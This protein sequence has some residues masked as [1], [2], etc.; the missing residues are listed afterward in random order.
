VARVLIVEG[1]DRGL[2]LARGLIEQGHAVRIT[3]SDSTRREAI[4]ASG[5]ECA[6]GTP[7]RLSTL[8]G[9]LEHVT[10]GCWLLADAGGDPEIVR[11]LHGSRLRQFL[12]SAIDSTLRGFLYE[13]GGEQVPAELLALGERI[14][15]ETAASNS[16]PTVVVRADPLDLDAWLTQVIAAIHSLLEGRES[17]A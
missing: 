15:S 5:A 2:R 8:R 12:A 1:A 6:I 10:I 16:I 4:E 11:A 3:A 9:V 13:A 14:V 7:E 17:M